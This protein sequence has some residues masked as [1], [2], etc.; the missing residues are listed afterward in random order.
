VEAQLAAARLEQ[1]LATTKDACSSKVLITM[2]AR[3]AP[4]STPWPTTYREWS[5]MRRWI[6]AVA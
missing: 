6:C 5:S 1:E 3:S 2:S 4:S